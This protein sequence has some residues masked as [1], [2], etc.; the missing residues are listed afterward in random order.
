MDQVIKYAL[1]K[2]DSNQQDL[3]EYLFMYRY[4]MPTVEDVFSLLDLKK[5]DINMRLAFGIDRMSKEDLDFISIPTNF[6]SEDLKPELASYLTD[7]YGIEQRS[8]WIFGAYYFYLGYLEE[9]LF[10][11]AD[12]DFVENFLTDN[13]NANIDGRFA[14]LN[15]KTR[16]QIRIPDMY[17]IDKIFK[18]DETAVSFD[19]NDQ[20]YEPMIH[21]VS[22]M[23]SKVAFNKIPDMSELVH[24]RFIGFFTQ[25][26]VLDERIDVAGSEVT[27]MQP[28]YTYLQ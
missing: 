11:G 27:L 25:N 17:K 18:K 5:E 24:K 4:K 23:S 12:I 28:D 9:L 10:D 13:S 3:R 1:Y 19:G 15:I 2:G 6:L 7:E 16:D 14:T 22:Q 20:L 21:K 26:L 8:D